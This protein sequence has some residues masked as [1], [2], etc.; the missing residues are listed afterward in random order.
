MTIQITITGTAA[1]VRREMEILLGK[2]TISPVLEAAAPELAELQDNEP[3]RGRGRP[4]K[5]KT[6]EP[7]LN[8]VALAA[9][10]HREEDEAKVEAMLAPEV[11][12]YGLKDQEAA[13]AALEQLKKVIEP[14]AEPVPTPDPVG[15]P[16]PGNAQD[17]M[18]AA[19]A[20]VAGDSAKKIALV[21]L[22]Q[23]YGAK[24]INTLDPENYAE[25]WAKVQVL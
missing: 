12:T 10:A 23:S 8:P 14:F 9:R 21:K 17:L 3:K 24:T 2:S 22:L 4:K 13:A 7:E 6:D 19:M 15:T 16:V 18:S 11:I 5:E 1:E 25:F 20:I